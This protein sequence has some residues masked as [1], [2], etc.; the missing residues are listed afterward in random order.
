VPN[1]T[2]SHI[3]ADGE[4]A[5][6]LLERLGPS[7][8]GGT[9]REHAAVQVLAT[10]IERLGLRATEETFPV[11]TFAD[12]AGRLEMLDP[13]QAVVP[14]EPVG[15][16][17]ETPTAGLEAPLV[18]V[19]S[20]APANLTAAEG[21]VA[22]TYGSLDR[23]KI[24][25]LLHAR[26]AGFVCIGEPGR[27]AVLLSLVPE[28]RTLGAPPPGVSIA[29]EDGLRLLQQ[30]ARTIRLLLR[31]RIFQGTSRNLVAEVPGTTR[32]E[33]VILIGAHVDSLRD[34]DGAHDNGAGTVAAMELLRHYVVHPARR[35]LRFVWFG[36]EEYGWVGSQ[37]YVERHAADLESLV[38]ML[39]LDVGG[40]LLG[41]DGVDVMGPPELTALFE[42][43]NREKGLDLLVREKVY[44]G[45]NG[46][47]AEQGIPA[48]TFHRG[49][50]T[51]QY[52]HTPNDR[53]DLVDGVHLA[54]LAMLSGCFLDRIA[55]AYHFPIRRDVPGKILKQVTELRERYL[56]P[57]PR[58]GQAQE[59]SN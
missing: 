24:R 31:Q 38:F 17:G 47:F 16:S 21:K 55:N 36:S 32:P 48:A 23:F 12:A 53:L 50:G 9:E 42:L 58:S 19:E 22:L 29:F 54:R 18:Y 11:L 40:G 10:E 30:R 26:V 52:I 13:Y 25:D 59:A 20:G 37:A 43:W 3:P 5:Y 28:W 4:R 39:N 33:E 7:R 49:L 34:M 8:L 51:A 2:I 14:C 15:L 56:G 44:G 57:R 35:T 6:D 1:P 41:Q 45:D 46:P 27:P